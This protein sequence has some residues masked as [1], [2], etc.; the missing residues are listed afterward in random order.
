MVTQQALDLKWAAYE[1][2]IDFGLPRQPGDS[3]LVQW[4]LFFGGNGDAD[5]RTAQL[6]HC[7]YGLL[8]HLRESY[9]GVAVVYMP[10]GSLSSS[11]Q[12][13]IVIVIRELK[14][15]LGSVHGSWRLLNSVSFCTFGSYNG[16]AVVLSPS[17][18]KSDFF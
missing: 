5:A 10:H 11:R 17:V 7:I 3:L 14:R 9:Y 1:A 13:W 12:W 15:S 18:Q 2:S 6:L 4:T 8:L 16:V